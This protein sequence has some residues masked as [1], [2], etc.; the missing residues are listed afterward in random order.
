MQPRLR[1]S[2]RYGLPIILFGVLLTLPPYIP[3]YLRGLFINTFIFSIFA[4]S[5]DIVM[6]YSGL[7]SIMHASFFG[8][9]AYTA[10]VLMVK[11]DIP[12]FW[13]GLPCGVIVAGALAAILG[14]VALRVPGI[15]FLIV[16]LSMGQMVYSIIWG[17]RYLVMYESEGIMGVEYPTLGIPGFT[18]DGMSYYYFVLFFLIICFFLLYRFVNSPFGLTLQGIREDEL[19]MCV[20]GYHTWFYKYIAFIIGGLFAG[21]AGVL[22]VYNNTAVLPEHLGFGYS[23]YVILMVILGGVGTLYGAIIGAGIIVFLE[24]YAGVM[25]PERWPLIFGL[26]LVLTIMFVR[27]GLAVHLKRHWKKLA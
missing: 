24:F 16:T 18:L 26:I 25:R 12:S 7:L 17:W 19:R 4:M 20:L 10:A 22:F 13:V 3:S 11:M 14:A 9:A 5:F 27:G 2:I 6:G 1:Q 21:V 15:Y 23:T 8:I